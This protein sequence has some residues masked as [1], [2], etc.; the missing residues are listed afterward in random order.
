M[1][2]YLQ[3][4]YNRYEYKIGVIRVREKRTKL[5][6]NKILINKNIRLFSIC[7]TSV[8]LIAIG[9][10]LM[11]TIKKGKF[12]EQKIPTYSYSN[13]AKVNY[14]VLLTPNNLYPAEQKSISEGNIYIK[15]LMDYIDTNFKY[16]F[17]GQEA[18]EIQGKYSIKAVV[19]GQLGSDKAKKTIW[20][21]EEQLLPEQSFKVNSNKH[22]IEAKA[23]LKP[24]HFEEMAKNKSTENGIDFTTK[25][26]VYWDV[27]I[28]AKTAKGNIREQLTPTMEIPMNTGKYFEITGNLTPEKKGTLETTVKVISHTYNKKI[29]LYTVIVVICV[30]ALLFL[31]FGA[32]NKP[33]DNPLQLKLKKIFKNHGDRLVRLVNE[34]LIGMVQLINVKEFE[35]LVRIA[36]DIGRPIFYR[37]REDTNEISTFY[38]FDEKYIYILQLKEAGQTAVTQDKEFEPPASSAM[39]VRY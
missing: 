38:V 15:K 1:E 5:K 11:F 4:L 26:T 29:N 27:Q 36:D 37:D 8:L 33:S 35:D 7:A 10:L 16:E 30:L 18:A 20:K 6:I 14:Q 32:Y 21:Y 22:V 19:E 9:I 24:Q 28:E 3:K 23:Q 34:N 12:I 31:L 17:N 25:L 13:K 39:F 2:N